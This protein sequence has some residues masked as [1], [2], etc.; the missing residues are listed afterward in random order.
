VLEKGKRNVEILKQNQHSPLTVEEQTAIIYCGTKGLVSTVP[1]NKIKDF[2]VEF[3][4]VMHEKKADVLESLRQGKYTDA[5]T[6]AI[7][8]IAAEA[9][10]GYQV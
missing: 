1:V 10:K 7:E 2:E 6:K 5:E 3:L 8:E 9:C 4:R